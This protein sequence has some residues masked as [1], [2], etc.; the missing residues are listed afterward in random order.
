MNDSYASILSQATR[1]T[2]QS[3]PIL[4]RGQVKNSAGGYV[5][6]ASDMAV[7]DRFLIL[8]SE[9]SYYAGKTDQTLKASQ[10]LIDLIKARGSEVVEKTVAVSAGFRAPKNDPAEFVLALCC[11]YGDEDV[12]K[13]A[14][15]AITQV[16][17]TGTHLFH[18]C[19]A[20]NSLRGWSAGL[21]NGVAKFYT[22]KDEDQ[23]ALQL[24]KYRQRGGWTHKDVLRL[25]HPKFQT[26]TLNDMLRWSVGKPLADPENTSL[27]PLIEAF[28]EVQDAKDA[29]DVI[30]L[31]RDNDLP[32]EALPTQFL[33]EAKVWEALLPSCPVNALVRNLGRLSSLGLTA[34]LS[35]NLR[36]IEAKLRDPK[37]LR[38]VH[39]LQAL[40]ALRVY[41][42]GHGDKGSLSWT[43]S[44][45][46]VSL[47]DELFY[48]SFGHVDPI[49]KKVLTATDVSG[50]MTWHAIAGMANITPR[51][52]AAALAMLYQR[53]E[54]QVH[55]M[56]FGTRF[57]S[58]DLNP[59][60]SLSEVIAKT[61]RMGAQGTDCSLPMVWALENRVEVDTFQIFTDNETWAGRIHPTQALEQY[62]QKMGRNATL[63]VNAMELNNF[64]VADPKDPR[65]LDVCGFDTAVP[66]VVSAFCRQ[67]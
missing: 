18:F 58:L 47:L 9:G 37:Q 13:Q 27:H 38:K 54:E 16:C 15:A 33:A 59:R 66:N 25:S 20:V 10:T 5:F 64:S 67:F 30:R 4:G 12:K 44:A 53:T 17:R 46:V 8:G 29:K 39:P 1:V 35:D 57:Q 28:L 55:N 62:R 6:Q 22:G 40:V 41:E 11:T 21:R 61:D 2:R 34:P 60:M 52:A 65:Q 14:Y 3:Q 42:Q 31:V 19:E 48:A 51:D 36:A 32:W 7:L 45:K 24:V 26:Q 63:V 49:G 23:V 56:A 50:S 43:P